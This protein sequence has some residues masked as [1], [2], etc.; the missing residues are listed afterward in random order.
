MKS[1]L[2]LEYLFSDNIDP[3]ESENYYEIIEI[4]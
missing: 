1:N 3:E 4:Y 2:L